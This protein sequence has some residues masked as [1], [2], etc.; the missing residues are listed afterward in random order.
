MFC[1]LKL[2]ISSIDSYVN[3]SMNRLS[4]S[5]THPDSVYKGVVQTSVQNDI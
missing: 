2:N 5:S 3:L 4:I 1:E